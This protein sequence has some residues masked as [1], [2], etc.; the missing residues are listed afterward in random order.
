MP[1][2]YIFDA[3]R[4]PRGKGEKE[5]SLYEVKPIELL[6]TVFRAIVA[7]NALDTSKIDDAIIGCVTA[8]RDQGANIAKIAAIYAGWNDRVGGMTIN[9]RCASGLEACNLAAM[10]VQS[11]N[12]DL[13]LAGGVESMSRIGMDEDQGDWF[14]NPLVNDATAYIPQGIAADLIATIE[15]F[16]RENLDQWAN[17]SH[18]KAS[19]AKKSGY[20][21]QSLIPVKDLNGLTILDHDEMIREG[22][23]M[24][25]LF[26]LR[27]SFGQMGEIGFDAT[28]MSGYPEIERINH[29]HHIGNSSGM[30]DGAAA[31][32]IGSEQ[33]GK[34]LGL[35]PRAKFRAMA[36]VG[37]EPGTMFT[38]NVPAS[39]KALKKA[40]LTVKDIDLFEVN[41]IFA[42]VVLKWQQ[43]M[44]I[45]GDKINPNGG[46][47]AMGHPLG[48]T[49]AMLL[50]ML[51]DELE[52][53]DRTLGL[54]ALSA[55]GGIGV[56]TVIER[57]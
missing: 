7:R 3:V 22:T 36:V 39:R 30:A 45:P 4:T 15:G 14:V 32:L 29:V 10:K 9:R 2:A 11:G 54:C 44:E 18:Q 35:K 19:H 53:Q 51:L 8:I 47:V 42:A 37:S 43:D 49:G 38:G 26:Q 27:P 1:E 20:F 57:V 40:G 24:E 21:D 46:T 25:R 48:A 12:D 5:G 16:D 50:G 55:D 28:A 23:S 56:S 41:E 17:D 31:V 6:V 52:R 34:C 13:F 33:I